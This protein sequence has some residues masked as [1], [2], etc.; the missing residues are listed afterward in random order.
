M[1]TL[2]TFQQPGSLAKRTGTLFLSLFVYSA[3]V[4]ADGVVPI[5]QL[6]VSQPFL[7]MPTTAA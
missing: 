1:Y 7:V 2:S 3:H 5:A 6:F 4:Y